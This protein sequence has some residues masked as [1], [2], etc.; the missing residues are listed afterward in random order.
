MPETSAILFAFLAGCA[1]GAIFFGGL[2]W[3]V[4][5]GVSSQSPA[6]WF[7]G[8]L[9]VRMGIVLTGF[10]YAGYGD[11]RRIAVCMTGF[12]LA[13]LAVTRMIPAQKEGTS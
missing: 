11:W 1:L 3:T 8:S 7:S 9:L 6:L 10:Y 4:R 5:K 12:L 13:R 2:W